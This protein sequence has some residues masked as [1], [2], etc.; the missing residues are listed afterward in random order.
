MMIEINHIDFSYS[1]RH[2]KIYSDFS[3]RIDEG[4]I[5]GLLGL[6]GSGKSTLLYLICGLLAPNRGSITLNGLP[7]HKRLPQTMREVYLVPEEI[8]LPALSYRQLI[9][10]HHDYYPHFSEDDLKT[11]LREF[12]LP[13]TQDFTAL[14]MGERK[15]VFMSFALASNTRYLLMD[16]PT[17]GLDIPSK[18]LFRNAITS[19][20]SGERLAIVSTHQVHDVEQ[21]L[22]HV[23]LLNKGHVDVN[24][25]T[26]D[27]LKQYCFS[28][29]E[30]AD[31]SDVVYSEPTLNGYMVMTHRKEGDAATPLNLELYFNALSNQNQQP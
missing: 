27:L 22:T 18:A 4:G 2:K 15:K 7:A 21:I 5:Y 6:N 26:A 28:F 14:S 12:Q 10:L 16:E 9:A 17:N 30:N 24:T 3:L 13:P 29:C 19:H 23:L 31:S 20:V 25:S 1:K 11:C 8:E